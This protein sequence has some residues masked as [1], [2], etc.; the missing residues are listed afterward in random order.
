MARVARTCSFVAGT[1]VRMA[2]GSLKP[3]EDLQ[4][5]DAIVGADPGTGELVNEVVI[6]PLVS[7]GD[8][9]LI[10]LWF[11]QGPVP[12]IATDNHPYWVDGVGWVQAGSLQPGDVTATS[13]G[14]TLVLQDVADLGWFTDQAVYNLRA[15]GTHTYFVTAS[16]DQPDQL[17][18]NAS[19]CNITPGEARRIQNAA[20][21]IGHDIH[22]VGSRASGRSHAW[23]DWDYVITGIRSR[24]RHSVSS[25]LPRGARELGVGKRLDIFSGSLD[26]SLPHITFLTRKPR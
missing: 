15:S 6:E 24:V 2:D 18:H 4:P 9:H 11:G 12:V 10:A 3:I 7:E 5:G 8:K 25:S 17:V 16:P 1:L 13:A 19:A 23:S 14:T 21:R 20:D 22:L 26:G